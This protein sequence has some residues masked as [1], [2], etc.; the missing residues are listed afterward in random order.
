MK[1]IRIYAVL[2]SCSTMTFVYM[3]NNGNR[4]E[5]LQLAGGAGAIALAGCAGDDN[6]DDPTITMG[7]SSDGSSSWTIGQ[8][9]QAEVDRH[10]DSITL[11][12]ERTD[13]FSA[14][15]GL[16]SGGDV[17]SIM[18]FNNMYDDAA[19]GVGTSEG[20][21][22]DVDEIGWQGGAHQ[23]GEY[24][25]VTTEDSDI[26]YYQ[27]LVG[28]DVA[29]APTGTGVHPVFHD[30]LDEGLGI[31]PEEDFNRQDLEWGDHSSALQD[32]RIE[33]CIM[34]THNFGE[35]WSGTW[36]ELAAQNDIEPLQIHPDNEEAA[37]E[38]LGPLYEVMDYPVVEDAAPAF[39]GVE[40]PCVFMV[41]IWLIDP[42]SPADAWYEICEI[43][44]ENVD[45]LQDA[46]PIVW[47]L[48]TEQAFTAGIIEDYPIHPGV[49]EFLQDNDW[50]DDAWTAGE[51]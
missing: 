9:M 48:D 15:I 38:H 23:S 20:E 19:Q 32:G 44:T 11:A 43:L 27:D 29:T 18:L 42:E 12:A 34:F 37:Q 3:L 6:G 4:R 10:S 2:I 7:T 8:A 46:S 33:A 16:M 49:A 21:E 45:E 41:V 51:Q 50:W 47:D 39:E 26:E 25:M 35:F 17:D 24:F 36:Q 1:R 31:D 14:N 40:A 22:F 30:F 5:F 13:G 28:R